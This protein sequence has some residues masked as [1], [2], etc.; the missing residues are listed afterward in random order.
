SV[1]DPFGGGAEGCIRRLP[2]D[3]PDPRCH[4]RPRAGCSRDGNHRAGAGRQDADHRR[5]VRRDQGIDRRLPPVRGRRP[6]RCDRAGL[7]DPGG[8]PRRRGRGA[9]DRGVVAILERV[10]LDQWGR[11]LAA[12]I[13]F[14]GDFDLAEEAAQEAFAI[15][16][17]RWPRGGT[18]ANP[19]P[20]LVTAARNRANDRI[21]RDRTLA[22]RTRLLRVP[23]R[24][25]STLAEATV[26]D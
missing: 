6:R 22:A 25:E 19:G 1:G 10:F 3:Q 12:L 14:L 18:P 7:A 24:A 23:A 5:P 21:R 26:P 13:G 15:A 4:P 17:E 9:S 20:W 16:A 11:V 2:G 8:T